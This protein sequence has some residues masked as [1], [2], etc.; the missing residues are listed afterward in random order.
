MALGSALWGTDSVLRRPLT[1]SLSSPV[2]VLWEHLILSAIAV[3]VLAMRWR[4]L[5]EM[6]A[7]DWLAVLGISWGGSALA[8][9]LF[10]AAIARGNVNTAVLL[11]KVQPL[12][13][14]LLAGPLLGER[15][16]RRMWGYLALAVAGAWLVSF[17]DRGLWPA[18]TGSEV[19]AAL[20]AL[21]A[22]ALWGTSTVLG[23]LLTPRVSF[24]AITLLRFLVALPLLVAIV[25]TQG[26]AIP[27]LDA[28]QFLRLAAMALVPGLA[29]LLL[30]YRGLVNTAAPA[31]AIAELAFPATAVILNWTF[32][33]QRAAPLQLVGFAIIWVVV[34]RI[35]GAAERNSSN[36]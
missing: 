32:L 19:S 26:A 12:F 28:N 16:S 9:V 13:T 7:R 25:V 34:A 4:E 10:T 30:Y 18:L 1:Q 23:R 3:P 2:I 33:N 29:A 6:R 22:S 8:T 31:A 5:R 35:Q 20:L 36:G 27:A 21:G 17:G 11:Q 14:F 24:P 15:L